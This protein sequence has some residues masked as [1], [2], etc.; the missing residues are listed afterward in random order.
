MFQEEEPDVEVSK[1]GDDVEI[2]LEVLTKKLKQLK[3]RK[4]DPR[5]NHV[6][7]IKNYSQNLDMLKRRRS[8]K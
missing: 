8:R 7:K 4:L 2:E 3:K 5:R 6:Q 1:Y